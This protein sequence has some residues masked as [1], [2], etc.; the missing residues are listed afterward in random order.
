[1]GANA[2]HRSEAAA[3]AADPAPD[4]WIVLVGLMGAGKSA[5]GRAL[6]AMTGR[7]HV[8]ADEEI[9][10][11]ARASIAEIFARDGERFFRAREAEIV[12]RVL[13]GPPGILSTGGGAW[14]SDE[15][16]AAVSARGVSV[17]LRAD[18]DTL[19]SR[20]KGRSHR[21]LL[22]GGDGR[23]VLRE[24]MAAREPRYAAADHAVDSRPDRGVQQTAEAV[25]RAL[26]GE[27]A[28]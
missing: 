15:V 11:A 23:A 12:G 13:A 6:G 10:R 4:R 17:W 3:A 21:P 26:R 24:L 18:L 25:L 14:M 9:E 19:W 28:G 7:A 16:R 22:Q 27:A 1:M 20:V 5:V 8:D 2:G